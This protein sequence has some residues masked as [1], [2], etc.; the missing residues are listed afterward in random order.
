MSS[1][2]LITHL[3]STL[4]TPELR[5]RCPKQIVENLLSHNYS[6]NSF[7]ICRSCLWSLKLSAERSTCMSRNRSVYSISKLLLCFYRR[8]R[9]HSFACHPPRRGSISGRRS[10]ALDMAILSHV[11]NSCTIYIAH[12]ILDAIKVL[13]SA[14]DWANSISVYL[15]LCPFSGWCW[16]S[17]I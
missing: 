7:A 11:R 1:A 14:I 15:G 8:V 3:L 2:K 10:H 6:D 13:M 9:T 16:T 5:I 12:P 17:L 4:R